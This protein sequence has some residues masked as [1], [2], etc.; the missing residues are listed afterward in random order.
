MAVRVGD[1][2]GVT[3]VVAFAVALGP[4]VPVRIVVGSE[5]ELFAMFESLAVLT[6]AAL[7]TVGYAALPTDTV[8]VIVLLAPGANGPGFVQVTS[9]PAAPQLHDEPMPDTKVKPAGSGS[10]TVMRPVVG[11]P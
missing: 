4:G 3:I 1:T 6:M 2:P 5:A 8:S 11:P 10:L 9:W 7:V